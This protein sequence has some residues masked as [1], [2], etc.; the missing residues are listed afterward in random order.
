MK[1][2][3]IIDIDGIA[4]VFLLSTIP[5]MIPMNSYVKSKFATPANVA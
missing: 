2:G 5:V 1:A 3:G 4:A